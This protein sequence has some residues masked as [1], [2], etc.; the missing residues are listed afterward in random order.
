LT[1]KSTTATVKARI[2]KVPEYHSNRD[3]LE[4]WILQCDLHFHVND[5]IDESDKGT[6]AS[7]RL[8]GDAFK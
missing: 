4:A 3:Q 6:L 5:K 8:R 7:T 1:P 2:D